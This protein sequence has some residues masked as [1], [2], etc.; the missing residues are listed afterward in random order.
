MFL[1]DV[2]VPLNI[3]VLV[4]STSDK[5]VH[6]QNT[7]HILDIESGFKE[8]CFML[9][10]Y[11]YVRVALL[12]LLLQSTVYIH[13]CGIHIYFVA[14]SDCQM[15]LHAYFHTEIG[16]FI[17]RTSTGDKSK[18]DLIFNAFLRSFNVDLT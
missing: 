14:I 10:W 13:L 6:L 17:F 1:T 8:Q 3:S 11:V 15:Y 5:S 2:K 4:E 18:Q 9:Y 16:K 12:S 7:E